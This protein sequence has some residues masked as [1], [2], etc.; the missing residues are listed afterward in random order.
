MR[1]TLDE[2]EKSELHWKK[3]GLFLRKKRWPRRLAVTLLLLVLLLVSGLSL[4][5]HNFDNLF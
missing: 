5:P 4:H 1:R 2:L 3:R